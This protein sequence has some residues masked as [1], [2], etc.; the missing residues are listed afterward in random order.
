MLDPAKISG[1]GIY[2]WELEKEGEA[3]EVAVH[4]GIVLNDS[5]LI[6]DAARAGAGLAYVFEGQV[7][8]DLAAGRLIRVLEDWCPRFE[9]FFPIIPAAN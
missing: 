2:R 9:G 3:L 7:I 1:G 4:G 8:A 5:G 6:V